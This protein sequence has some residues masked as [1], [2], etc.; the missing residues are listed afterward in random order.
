MQQEKLPSSEALQE[1][2]TTFSQL[3]EQLA[4]SY[5]ALEQRVTELNDE[6][7]QSHDARL[8]ELTEKERLAN[9]L[10]SL[11]KALPGGVVVIDGAG[12]VQEHNPIAVELLGEPLHGHAWRDVIGRAFSP[13][14]DD[15]HEVSLVDGRRVNISTCPLGSEPGQILLITDVTEIRALQDR[16]SQQRRLAAMGEMAASLAHQ[17]RTPLSS[18][19]L[20]TSNLKLPDLE[21]ANRDRF[22][23]KVRSRLQHLERIVNDM[24][25]YARSGTTGVEEQFRAGDLLL[26]LEHTLDSQLL[27]KGIECELRDDTDGLLMQGNRE[28]LLS[29]LVNLCVNAIQAMGAD[30]W[31]KISARLAPGN[32]LELSVSDNGAG[33]DEEKQQQIFN[34][35]FTT[36]SEGTGLG[37]AVVNA[38]IRAHRGTIVVDSVPGKGTTFVL[39]LPIVTAALEPVAGNE[40]TPVAQF[41]HGA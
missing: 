13:R 8:R 10:S 6:L 11:L 17:I 1:A 32:N 25:L 4:A 18:A 7:S 41:S 3:S 19:L 27:D 29:A 34:P 31:L 5:Q 23:D 16:L 39:Q 12:I 38:V 21:E 33:M 2:F 35:F 20:Y 28:M 36:R 22:I 40:T 15:G 30:G 24:L 26:A 14:C 37:L 9:R